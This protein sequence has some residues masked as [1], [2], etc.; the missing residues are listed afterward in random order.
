MSSPP[1][2]CLSWLLVVFLPVTSLW[3]EERSSSVVPQ[4]AELQLLTGTRL[5]GVGYKELALRPA[6]LP[7]C[8]RRPGSET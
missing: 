3:L 8:G 7:P 1:L 4:G 6:L 2:H 5:P